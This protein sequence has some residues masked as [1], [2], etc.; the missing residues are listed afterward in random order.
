MTDR[1][2]Q[3]LMLEYM[4]FPDVAWIVRNWEF[5]AEPLREFAVKNNGLFKGDPC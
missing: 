3:A 2:E 4:G 5:T 1:E